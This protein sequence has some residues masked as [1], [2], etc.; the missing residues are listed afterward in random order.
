MKSHERIRREV[1]TFNNF[2]KLPLK[3][4]E[5]LGSG[6]L[7]CGEWENRWNYSQSPTPDSQTSS[8]GGREL[9]VARLRLSP[10]AVGDKLCRGLAEAR[11]DRSRAGGRVGRIRSR[12][13]C[14]AARSARAESPWV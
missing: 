14:S 7:A 11:C 1:Y 12:A 10:I 6:F 8:F 9:E 2:R 3:D 4:R 5:P 13:A